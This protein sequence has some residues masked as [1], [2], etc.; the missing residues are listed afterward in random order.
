M[1]CT[2]ELINY[3]VLLSDSHLIV[4]GDRPSTFLCVSF[5]KVWTWPRLPWLTFIWYIRIIPFGSAGA[6][7]D[8]SRE[9]S[10][11]LCGQLKLVGGFGSVI[12][13]FF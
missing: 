13:S 5:D 1:A 2:G 4:P 11:G 9:T 6:I 3:E 8:I 10:R 12:K 7:H